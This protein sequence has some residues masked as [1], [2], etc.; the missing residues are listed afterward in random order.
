MS[1]RQRLSRFLSRFADSHTD[2]FAEMEA[3]YI[4][5]IDFEIEYG[6]GATC[7]FTAEFKTPVTDDERRGLL[8]GE[9]DREDID[10]WHPS[11]VYDP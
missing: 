6:S 11:D 2:P 3:T 9:L 5:T 1:I 7:R 4:E 10:A 8:R